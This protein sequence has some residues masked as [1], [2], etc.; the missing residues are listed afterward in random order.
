ML[1]YNDEGGHIILVVQ[2]NGMYDGC[3]LCEKMNLL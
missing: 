2:Y 1:G 3:G